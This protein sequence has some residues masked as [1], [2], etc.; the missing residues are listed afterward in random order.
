[1]PGENSSFTTHVDPKSPPIMNGGG[2]GLCPRVRY[3]YSE[4]RLSP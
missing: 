4:M 2:A 1:M 3:A